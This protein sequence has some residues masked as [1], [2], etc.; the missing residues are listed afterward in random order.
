MENV[1]YSDMS[2]DDLI[3]H[4]ERNRFYH[5][6]RM[7]FDAIVK[8]LYLSNGTGRVTIYGDSQTANR[9]V[10]LTVGAEFVITLSNDLT[11]Q[12]YYDRTVERHFLGAKRSLGVKYIGEHKNS[13]IHQTLVMDQYVEQ[14]NRICKDYGFTHSIVSTEDNYSSGSVELVRIAPTPTK[15]VISVHRNDYRLGY[16]TEAKGPFGGLFG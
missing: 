1:L 10:T 9:K 5:D 2:V 13:A 8:R 4:S 7:V 16:N 12:E 6:V 11:P 14:L 15:M 3:N